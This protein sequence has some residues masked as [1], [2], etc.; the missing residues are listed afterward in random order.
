MKI[1]RRLL[2]LFIFIVSI[3]LF[4]IDRFFMPSPYGIASAFTLSSFYLSPTVG[5]YIPAGAFPPALSFSSV[6]YSEESGNFRKKLYN[7]SIPTA[8]R[9][10]FRGV[11]SSMIVGAYGSFSM[12]KISLNNVFSSY[13]SSTESYILN[14]FKGTVYGT[15]FFKRGGGLQY[16]ISVKKYSGNFY[17]GSVKT[18]DYFRSY[19]DLTNDFIEKRDK[20]EPKEVSFY[21]I[22]GS[23]MMNVYKFLNISLKISPINSVKIENLDKKIETGYEGG[24]TLL[25][26]RNTTLDFSLA[27][28]K[29][30]LFLYDNYYTKPIK[31]SATHFFSRNSFLT[32]GWLSDVEGEKLF[33]SGAPS[34]LSAGLGYVLGNKIYLMGSA[35]ISSWNK[36]SSLNIT[37]A[38]ITFNR[39]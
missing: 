17:E 4:A 7:S 16:G 24:M 2:F 8:D 23:I 9:N 27:L 10:Y 39:R 14:G 21:T 18:L 12:Y 32:L 20:F 19:K 5:A 35:S 38:Y 3:P 29:Q 30:K 22:S 31:L 37:I 34:T 33:S 1:K 28:K 13:D 15:S 6:N 26:S 25:L 11:S 36:L